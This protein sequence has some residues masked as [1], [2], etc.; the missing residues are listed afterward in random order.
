MEGHS[1]TL[2]QAEDRISELEDEM[3]I[4]G[5][6]EELL[7]NSRPVKEYARTHQ[8]HQKTKPETHGH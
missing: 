1:S 3:E 5:R 4:K 8:L 7:V 6:N 2:K